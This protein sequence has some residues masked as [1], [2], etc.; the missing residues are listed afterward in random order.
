MNKKTFYLLVFFCVGFFLLFLF[1]VFKSLTT[2]SP[3]PSM[4]SVDAPDLSD[5]NQPPEPKIIIDINTIIAK[6][7]YY[8]TY[9]SFDYNPNIAV[10]TVNI[11]PANKSKGEKEFNEFLIQNG[12]KDKAFLVDLTT[13][14]LPLRNK[15]TPAP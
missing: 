11:D 5:K 6:T 10:F 7:P 9:F 1:V 15:T 13:T 4:P 12:I 14:Y 3:T 8:G 2:T